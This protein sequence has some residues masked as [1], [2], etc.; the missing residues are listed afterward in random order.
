MRS[1][2]FLRR[3]VL[4]SC[5]AGGGEVGREVGMVLKVC[6]RPVVAWESSRGDPVA[7]AFLQGGVDKKNEIIKIKTTKFLL[8]LR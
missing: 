4:G 6:C 7:E 2:H 3:L 8:L 1:K 5:C